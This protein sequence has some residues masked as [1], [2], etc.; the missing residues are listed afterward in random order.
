MLWEVVALPAFPLE[1]L[2]DLLSDIP[3]FGRSEPVVAPL[4]EVE[5]E[6]PI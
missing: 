3:T 2:L 5:V 6:L 1:V 4:F